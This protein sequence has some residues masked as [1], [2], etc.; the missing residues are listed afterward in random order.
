[1]ATER[2]KRIKHPAK[3]SDAL[4]PVLAEIVK[5][6]GC[7]NI[8]DPFAGTGRI[9]ELWD[10]GVEADI[11]AVEIEP[12]WASLFQMTIC[13]DALDLPWDGGY[14]DCICTSPTYGNRLADHHNAKDASKR[15]GYKF[16]LGRDL[17]ENNSGKLQWGEDYRFFHRDAWFEALRVLR[18][19]GIFILNISDHIRGGRVMPVTDWHART[20]QAWGARLIEHHKIETPRLRY[21]A[22]HRARVNHESVIVFRKER[23]GMCGNG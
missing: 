9:F 17:H 11:T 23:I 3:Y 21:G 5:R 1:M 7:K 20:L 2:T 8:L 19:G 13:A 18:D 16:A 4:I 22:N 15:N 14:F 10:H 6:Y 12:E